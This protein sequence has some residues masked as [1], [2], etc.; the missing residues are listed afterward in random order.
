MILKKF[1]IWLVK[2][3]IILLLVTFIFSAVTLDFPKLI[4]GIFSDVYGY[5]SPEAQKE[6][7]GSLAQTCYE[8]NKGDELTFQDIC[9][10]QSARQQIEDNCIQYRQSKRQ[11]M[12]FENEQELEETCY[13][14]ESG[15]IDEDCKKMS[16][17]GAFADKSKLGSLCR[18]YSN[19]EIDD[20]QFFAGFIGM[21]IGSQGEPKIGFLDK[22]HKIMNFLNSNKIIYFM[23]ILILFAALYFITGNTQEFL[24]IVAGISLSLG[25]VIMLPYFG[26]IMY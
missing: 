11:G 14:L 26:I 18:S 2:S 6:A 5:S 1:L 3:I 23:V 9:T 7:I 17:A 8:L 24:L 15:Q 25:I 10:N 19:Q 21:Y 20:K 12:Q 4:S 16:D 22:Y 13:Q